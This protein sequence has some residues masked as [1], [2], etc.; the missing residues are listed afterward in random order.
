MKVIKEVLFVFGI[1]DVSYYQGVKCMCSF[2]SLWGLGM[3]I[4]LIMMQRYQK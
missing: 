3:G 4:F 2:I 1:N